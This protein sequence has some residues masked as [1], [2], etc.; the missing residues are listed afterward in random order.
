MVV[1]GFERLL[2][3]DGLASVLGTLMPD[4][5]VHKAVRTFVD[6]HIRS[7]EELQLLIAMATAPER[8][9]DEEAVAREY[10]MDRRDARSALEHLAAHNLLEIKVT[11]DVRYQFRPGTPELADFVAA[12]L[13]V[14]R[15]N[16]IA[17][18]RL[19]P[20]R[21]ERRSIRDFADAFRMWRD[22]GR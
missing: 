6:A 18:W 21:R 10:T 11:G 9:W 14:Y 19:A 17:L 7:I 13:D 4:Q 5:P 15:T 1:P 16:S 8:W 12:C 2:W 20:L 22:D 3:A